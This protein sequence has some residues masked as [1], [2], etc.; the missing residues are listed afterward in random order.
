MRDLFLA[1]WPQET[2]RINA[3]CD[4]AKRERDTANRMAEIAEIWS[5][6]AADAIRAWAAT[7]GD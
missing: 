7:T 4:A 1:G 5:L 6:E 3:I 2:K